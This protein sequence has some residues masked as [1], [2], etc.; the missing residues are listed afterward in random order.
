MLFV[1]LCDNFKIKL[2]NKNK[3]PWNLLFHDEVVID[4]WLTT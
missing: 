2:K 4:V 1:I 3:K